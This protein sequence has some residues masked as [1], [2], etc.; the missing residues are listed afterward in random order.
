MIRETNATKLYTYLCVF[1]S[2]FC[3][4]TSFEVEIS[5][6]GMHAILGHI[7]LR[8]GAG[9]GRSCRRFPRA[10]SRVKRGPTTRV[11]RNRRRATTR[12][13]IALP[14]GKECRY[15]RSFA[16]GTSRSRDRKTFPP[17]P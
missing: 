9:T 14:D 1:I 15:T 16:G 5:F 2:F 4:P 8:P 11:L 12:H 7:L 17:T 13:P 3:G 6:S 10:G